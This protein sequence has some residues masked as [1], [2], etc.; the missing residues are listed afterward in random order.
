MIHGYYN[1]KIMEYP[2][3]GLIIYEDENN[4]LHVM[5]D[6]ENRFFFAVEDIE[7]EFSITLSLLRVKEAIE[8]TKN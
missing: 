3:K 4:W 2:D 5:D 6:P 1:Y 8:R 7:V